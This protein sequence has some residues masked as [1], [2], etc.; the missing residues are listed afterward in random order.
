MN[1]KTSMDTIKIAENVW[2]DG[3]LEK[4]S[5]M[6]ETLFPKQTRLISQQNLKINDNENGINTT[7]LYFNGHNVNSFL[8]KF[9][10]S[11]SIF[12][13]GLPL[14]I[15]GVFFSKELKSVL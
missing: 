2:L 4:S 5:Q 12:D 9:D 14:S 13:L 3:D 8:V 1:N 6:I 10:R 7:P 11:I 15:Q